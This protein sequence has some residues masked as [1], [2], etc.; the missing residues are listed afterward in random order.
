MF[1][2]GSIEVQARSGVTPRH[3]M[4]PVYFL[5][6]SFLCAPASRLARA[7]PQTL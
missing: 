3:I 7:G 4:K 2:A 1:A 5:I 6:A